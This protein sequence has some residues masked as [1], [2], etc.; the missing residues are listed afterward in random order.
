MTV[1]V[2]IDEQRRPYFVTPGMIVRFLTPRGSFEVTLLPDGIS[3]EGCERLAVEPRSQRLID[4]KLP[5]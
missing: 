1:P 2:E 4:I 3:I 5:L